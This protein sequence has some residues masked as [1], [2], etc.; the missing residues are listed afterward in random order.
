[1]VSR[2][3]ST[4]K[5]TKHCMHH[6]QKTLL[7]LALFVTCDS[8][9][10][11]KVRVACIGDSI[12]YG[13]GIEDRENDSYPANLQKILG[14]GYEV[15]NF[16]FNARTMSSCGDYPY[17]NEQ[18]YA[19]ARAFLP[20]IVVI[21]LGTNDTKP[22]NWNPE[23]FGKDYDRMV[24][25]W[26]RTPSCPDIYVCLPPPVI[27]DN[28]GITDS[29]V[30]SSVIPTVRSVADRH[31]LEIIDNNS[32]L[33]GKA[34]LFT[35]DGVHPNEA[36]AKVIAENVA[37]TLRDNGWG[38]KPGKKV[39]FLGDSITDGGWGKMDGRPAI[40]RDYYDQNHVY[41]HGY[42]AEC[43]THYME[44]YPKKHLRFYNRGISGDTIYG[45]SSRLDSE[46][47]SL[48]PDMV[49]ILVGV[50]DS[51][52]ATD[53]D[54][55]FA[56]WETEYRAVLDR[57]LA[58]SPGCRIVL[59]TPFIEKRG[60]SGRS[61]TYEVRRTTVEHLAEIVRAMASEYGFTCVDFARQMDGMLA[62]D[63][64]SDRNYWTW[65]GIHPTPQ[66]HLRM[67]RMWIRKA[68]RAI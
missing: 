19:D 41:G 65:D 55:D 6:I 33:Q 20:D 53:K 13:A 10:A 54:F 30:S 5:S 66:A 4:E 23:M 2:P 32:I 56:A 61:L 16:G 47:L 40:Q 63:K 64:S 7:I 17:M 28:F 59:C 24:S 68:G 9:A 60:A 51:H 26:K 36:G 25:E 22:H 3:G 50:N 67:A 21:M 11:D 31:W 49:S 48:R 43:I 52:S 62:R 27:T 15:V 57:I 37:A 18:M 58:S 38:D 1:M 14:E 34:D 35:Q 39:V 8:F 12:T 46:V 42:Q 29:L 44:K 45:I